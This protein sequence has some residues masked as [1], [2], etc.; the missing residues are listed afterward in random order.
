MDATHFLNSKHQEVIWKFKD[1]RNAA[2]HLEL[3]ALSV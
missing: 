3:E 2:M 1:H